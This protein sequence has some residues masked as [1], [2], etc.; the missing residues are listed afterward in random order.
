MSTALTKAKLLEGK[1]LLESERPEPQWWSGLATKHVQYLRLIFTDTFDLIDHPEFHAQGAEAK[2]FDELPP[3]EEPDTSWY[4]PVMEVP[5]SSTLRQAS[6]LLLT[7]D[8]EQ[9][10]F[11]RFN[12]CR[13]RVWLLKA[14]VLKLDKPSKKQK[15]SL[16]DWYER[17]EYYRHKIAKTNLALVLAMAKRA[18]SM[19]MEFPELVSEGNM[20]LLRAV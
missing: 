17:S 10:L 3:I 1:Q 19:D 11:K 8:Q 15:T 4:R 6:F 7:T 18:R 12:Y 5:S 2:I 14:D 13:H 20:A 9:L 16:L